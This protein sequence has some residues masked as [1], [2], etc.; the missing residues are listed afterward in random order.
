MQNQTVKEDWLNNF[1]SFNKYYVSDH[2]LF[3]KQL[4]VSS[5]YKISLRFFGNKIIGYNYILVVKSKKLHWN[6]FFSKESLYF[7]STLTQILSNSQNKNKL[8]VLFYSEEKL[9]QGRLNE[10][11]IYFKNKIINCD[12]ERLSK[13]FYFINPKLISSIGGEKRI[14][15]TINDYFQYWTK[16]NLS[17]FISFNDVDAFKILE[18]NKILFL[19]L[20]RPDE[21]TNT[22][23]PYLDDSANYKAG[24]QMESDIKK[25]KFI[26]ISYNSNQ[27]SQISV[28]KIN[29]ITNEKIFGTVSKGDPQSFNINS[30]DSNNN[31]FNFESD[32]RRRK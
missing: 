4:K 28:F 24:I 11:G 31:E 3:A 32:R 9:L 26:T 17:K 20:K 7:I 12:S 16:E 19:E 18:N 21:S 8:S 27:N 29:K 13:Y 30:F 15:K 23:L 5:D 1:L 14:N 25:L 6:N 10:F 2:E 22:W